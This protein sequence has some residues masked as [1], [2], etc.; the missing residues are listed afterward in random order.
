MTAPVPGGGAAVPPA[1]QNPS[2]NGAPAPPPDNLSPSGNDAP[3]VPPVDPEVAAFDSA[4]DKFLA[5]GAVPWIAGRTGDGVDASIDGGGHYALPANPP[6]LPAL[7]TPFTGGTLAA[8]DTITTWYMPQF[9]LLPQ[10]GTDDPAFGF[11]VTQQAGAVT[12]Q[13]RPVNQATLTLTLAAVLPGLQPLPVAGP[14]KTVAPAPGLQ[15]VV[16][17]SVPVTGS[18]GTVLAHVITG[19]VAA[20]A[21]ARYQVSF[22]LPQDVVEAAYE[23]LTDVGGVSLAATVTYSALELVRGFE[24]DTGFPHG[25]TFDGYQF[26]VFGDG[27]NPA[28]VPSAG[29]GWYRYLPVT[30]RFPATTP[31]APVPFGLAFYTDAYR[32]RYTITTKDGI[33]RPIIDESDLTG[34]AAA[35][36]QYRELTSL[37]D[38][39]SR[40]PTVRRAYLGQITGTVVALPAAY[41]IV[42]GAQGVAAACDALV[43]PSSDLTGSRFH[44]TFTLAPAVDPIDLAGLAAALPGLPEAAGRT[45]RL[46]LPD[47]LDSRTASV[48]SGFAAATATFVDGAAP[49]TVQ[50]GVDIGDDNTTPAL[51]SVN[52]FLGELCAAGP[53]P[54]SANLA[55]RLDDQF[56]EPVQAPGPLNLYSTAGSDDLTVAMTPGAAPSASNAGPLDLVLHRVAVLPQLSITSLGEEVLGAGKT[57]SLPVTLP[58]TVVPGTAAAVVVARSL[59]VPTPIPPQTVQSMVTF[60]TQ[61]VQQVQH[62]LTVQAAF[63]FAAAGVSSVQVAFQ[64]TALPAVSVPDLTLTA[65]HTVDFVHVLIPVETAITGLGTV[66]TLTLA[67]AGAGGSRVVT[68]HNDFIDNPI[69]NVTGTTI[70]AASA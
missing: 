57:V 61:D 33:T 20:Q 38:I 27:Q 48:L 40:F 18:D 54:L 2:G 44:F 46:T 17:L 68:V 7:D 5:S 47:G 59:A 34:F 4:F 13:G 51:T 52:L 64:V 50:V 49:Y 70:A 11:A 63:D 56:P 6:P 10:L 12:Q 53:A 39:A 58:V 1:G 15:P 37:G 29:L 25:P 28:A 67:L 66:V 32:S 55:V 24:P 41:G 31:P 35:R 45:L 30:A 14:G 23:L 62:P 21:G 65:A 22:A 69:L 16:T 36:S 9:A 43:D 60:R 19:T 8:P 26:A 42:H 3:P